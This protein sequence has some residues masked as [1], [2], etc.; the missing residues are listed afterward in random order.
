ME[1]ATKMHIVKMINVI[2]NVVYMAMGKKNVRVSIC[3]I[4]YDTS[5]DYLT[6]SYVVIY[7]AFYHYFY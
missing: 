4:Q 6:F 2:V 1:N 7:N 5:H 3:P